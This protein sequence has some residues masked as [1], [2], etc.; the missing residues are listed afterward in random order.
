MSK[1]TVLTYNTHAILHAALIIA[2]KYDAMCQA[3]EE[4]QTRDKVQEIANRAQAMQRYA[5]RANHLEIEAK[6]TQLRWRAERRYAELL[7]N[8][9]FAELAV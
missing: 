6:A 2:F 1:I 9:E 4:A 8:E 7:H 5:R 3:I